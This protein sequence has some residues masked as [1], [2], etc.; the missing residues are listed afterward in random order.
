MIDDL[1]RLSC[2]SYND[3]GRSLKQFSNI[4]PI[5]FAI[6]IF[7]SI[8]TELKSEESNPDKKNN[9]INSLKFGKQILLISDSTGPVKGLVIRSYQDSLFLAAMKIK[10]PSKRKVRLNYKPRILD[11]KWGNLDSNI[12]IAH[13]SIREIHVRGNVMMTGGIIGGSVFG[14]LSFLSI[15]LVE[16]MNTS[17]CGTSSEPVVSTTEFIAGMTIGTSVGIAIGGYLGSLIP[18]WN[19]KYREKDYKHSSEE[20]TISPF[21]NINTQS[22]Y[23]N[24]SFNADKITFKFGINLSW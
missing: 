18:K 6:I 2:Y 19:L 16:I 23:E 4:L 12:A 20:I 8:T 15:L 9:V 1:Y 11:P 22:N 24:E 5:I 17:T 13:N 7:I 10:A 3:W 14:V 21:V